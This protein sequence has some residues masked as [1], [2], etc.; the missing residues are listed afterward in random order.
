VSLPGQKDVLRILPVDLTH[1]CRARAAGVGE[2][3]H[4]GGQ[5]ALAAGAGRVRGGGDHLRNVDPWRVTQSRD[6]GESVGLLEDRPADKDRRGQRRG[7]GVAQNHP[8]LA[9]GGLARVEVGVVELGGQSLEGDVTGAVLGIGEK[10]QRSSGTE[11][12]SA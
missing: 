2:R 5:V 8:N 12:R 1:V 10:R 4:L 3:G 7:D 11:N 6:Q 9:V